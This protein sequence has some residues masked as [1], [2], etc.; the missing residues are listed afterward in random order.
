M[1]TKSPSTDQPKTSPA[2]EKPAGRAAAATTAGVEKVKGAKATGA[3]EALEE[4][5]ELGGFGI[6]MR[7]TLR[8][9]PSWLVSMVFHM[10]VLLVLALWMV[11]PGLGNDDQEIVSTS[12]EDD[13]LEELDVLDEELLEEIDLTQEVEALDAEVLPEEVEISPA[14]DMDSAAIQVELSEFGLEH[15]PRNDL[16]ATVGN[17][18]GNGLSGRG[19]RSGLRGAGGTAGSEAAVGA[20]LQWLANHQCP[21]GGWCF[22]L[23]QTPSCAGKCGNT[24]T[25]AKARNAATGLALL[26]FLGAGQTH[27]DGKY[28]D[29]VQAGLYY[30]VSHMKADP[31]YGPGSFH[32]PDRG[33]M[34]AHGIASIAMCEAY[35]MTKDKGLYQPAQMCVNFICNAQDPV[36]GGWRY[37]P[38][39]PGDTSVVGWQIMALKSGHMAYLQIPPITVKKAFAFLDSVQ[40]DSGSTYGYTAGR[41]TG[42][43]TT[44]IGLLCRM[45]LGWKKDHPALERGAQQ[46]G[47]WG[48]SSDLYY[49]YY[50]TQ[51]MRHW[52]GDLWKN[53]NNVMRDQLV[54]SQ[55][56]NKN[57]HEFGSWYTGGG[58]GP[59]D[60]GRL[61]CTAMAT[62]ILEV[63][64]RHLPIYRS[65]SVEEEFPE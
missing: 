48:P 17:Y 19:S 3:R 14:E 2:A 1:A 7:E 32:E 44:A 41:T 23:R 21:D 40:G 37:S 64:Y 42:H 29:T 16:L 15:A 24:G 52:E 11:D 9:A 36:G 12:A 60:A 27:K 28:K 25:L 54:N 65:Q 5:E 35:A 53:W 62:M 57:S 22:D 30:L 59:K 50:A 43:A 51:V 31:K 13:E 61:Y 38:R 63:Y 47:K 8:E 49:N 26:P 45:Y 39:Q 4:Q 34:Y 33:A 56:K 20:A 46:I 18:A 55:V 10:V 58:H 6:W